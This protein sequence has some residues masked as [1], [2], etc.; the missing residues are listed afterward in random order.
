M[1]FRS[2]CCLAGFWAEKESAN[3]CNRGLNQTHKVIYPKSCRKHVSKEL[4]LKLLNLSSAS[5]TKGHR[6]SG[7]SKIHWSMINIGEVLRVPGTRPPSPASS[8]GTREKLV[9]PQVQWSRSEAELDICLICLDIG[10][11]AQGTD[12]PSA[13]RRLAMQLYV[14]LWETL[15]SSASAALFFPTSL[16]LSLTGLCMA[17]LSSKRDIEIVWKTNAS[18]ERCLDRPYC[19]CKLA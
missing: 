18:T 6:S 12:P 8:G 17:S 10:C 3:N 19:C 15:I 16:D 13:E 5:Q 14:L 4:Y 1:E 2:A 9:W 7:N 11:T